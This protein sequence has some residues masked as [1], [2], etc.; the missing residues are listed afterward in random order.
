MGGS[1]ISILF[2]GLLCRFL[3]L[4]SRSNCPGGGPTKLLRG[5]TE[6]EAGA[7]QFGTFGNCCVKRNV[8][9]QQLV[10]VN[11]LNGL[12]ILCVGV[13]PGAKFSPITGNGRQI[14]I[15]ECYGTPHHGSPLRLKNGREMKIANSVRRKASSWLIF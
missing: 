5:G 12:S 2:P 6:E 15:G 7:C 8:A 9:H 14:T 1:C 10:R 4:N 3:L 13:G 11:R